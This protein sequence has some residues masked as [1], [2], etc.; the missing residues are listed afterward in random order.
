MT[1]RS[2]SADIDILVILLRKSDCQQIHLDSGIGLH[3]KGIKL[4]DIEMSIE[5]KKSLIGFRAFTGNDYISSFF[6]KS[7]AACWKI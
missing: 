4:S 2:H 3:R 7:R 5:K 1:V 6:G